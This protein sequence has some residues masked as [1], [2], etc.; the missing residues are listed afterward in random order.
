MASRKAYEARRDIPRRDPVCCGEGRGGETVRNQD[1]GGGTKGRGGWELTVVVMAVGGGRQRQS[2][3]R[4]ERD[5][6]AI[7]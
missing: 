1:G 2:V 6:E 3:E 4:T 7:E 5:E